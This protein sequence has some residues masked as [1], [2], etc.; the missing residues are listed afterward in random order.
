MIKVLTLKSKNVMK[1][2]YSCPTSVLVNLVAEQMIASSMGMHD[3]KTEQWANE[4]GSWESDSWSSESW[5]DDA[6]DSEF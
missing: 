2:R 5:S 6:S 4:K 3:D 1:K